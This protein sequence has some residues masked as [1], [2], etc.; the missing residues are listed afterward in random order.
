MP[1]CD[2][3]WQANC[4]LPRKLL[5]FSVSLEKGDRLYAKYAGFDYDTLGTRSG[6]YFAVVMYGTLAAAYDRKARDVEYGI[7]GH[8]AKALRGCQPRD[9][10]SYLLTDHRHVRD[11]FAAAAAIN[12]PLRRAEYACP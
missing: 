8:R 4:V 3:E 10:T 1:G 5:G 12:G 11:T 9:V 6:A 2:Q 7:G